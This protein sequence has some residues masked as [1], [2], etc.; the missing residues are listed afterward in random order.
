MGDG[1]DFDRPERIIGVVTERSWSQEAHLLKMTEKD[2]TNK[3]ILSLGSGKKNDDP[4]RVFSG[5]VV[6][7]LD[8]SF[9][10]GTKEEYEKLPELVKKS[11][12]IRRDENTATNKIKGLAQELPFK[13]ESFDLIIS[14]FS[15]PMYIPDKETQKVFEEMLRVCKIGG[16][17]RL[18]PFSTNNYRNILLF[19]DSLNVEYEL[20]NIQEPNLL[21]VRKNIFVND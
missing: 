12:V 21:V 3:S 17:I 6:T 10:T 19:L 9:F 7:A 1:K 15:V 4:N 13:D 14:T 5:A 2:W 20:M 8:P 11:L 16:E 18:Y